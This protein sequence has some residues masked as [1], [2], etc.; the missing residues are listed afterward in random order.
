MCVFLSAC[1]KVVPETIACSIRAIAATALADRLAA[2]RLAAYR[3][4]AYR[5]A[6]HT[7]SS[8]ALYLRWTDQSAAAV[9]FSRPKPKNLRESISAHNFCYF[10][11]ICK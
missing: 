2:D 6:E 10:R 3:L 7:L 5:L 9:H 1:C 8:Y 11:C 4:A